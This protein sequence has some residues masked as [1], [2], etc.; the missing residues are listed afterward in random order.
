MKLD[1][2]ALMKSPL[3]DYIGVVRFFLR[4]VRAEKHYAAIASDASTPFADLRAVVDAQ[5][6][7][8]AFAAGSPA[9]LKI[10]ESGDITQVAKSV[11]CPV[12]VDVVDVI[13]GPLSSHVEPCESV[14][15]TL[16]TV[17]GYDPI[18][19]L[20]NRAGHAVYESA[21]PCEYP[22]EYA[23][24]GI[25]VKKLAQTLRSKIRSSHEAVPSLIGQRPAGASNALRASLF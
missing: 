6:A 9:V 3:G 24:A 23:S 15:I 5:I 10:N 25:V 17:N 22:S 19:N 21:A 14:C 4:D 16:A 11:V 13:D 2:A 7:V 8:L 18:A 12:S 1:R 20:V